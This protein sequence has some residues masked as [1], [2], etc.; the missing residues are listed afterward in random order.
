MNEENKEKS[1]NNR[2]EAAIKKCTEVEERFSQFSETLKVDGALSHKQKTLISLA[3]AVAKSCVWC[4]RNHVAHALDQGIS[5]EQIIE[6]AAMAVHMDG[7]TGVA[8]LRHLALKA[9]EEYENGYRAQ[10]IG[11]DWELV[12][13]S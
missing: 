10:K 5:A 8:A 9:I 1:R 2:V 7:G 3:I 11:A 13:I 6:A 4:V 12:R